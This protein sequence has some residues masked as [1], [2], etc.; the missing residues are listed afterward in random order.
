MADRDKSTENAPVRI[1]YICQG[2]SG[3]IFL[4]KYYIVATKVVEV[5]NPKKSSK[6]TV[7]L[8]EHLEP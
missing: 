1:N 6:I 2:V 3:I 5:K 4:F 8:L 7:D